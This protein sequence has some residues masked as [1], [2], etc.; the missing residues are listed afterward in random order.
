VSRRSRLFAIVAAI[1]FFVL[2]GSGVATALWS[3]TATISANVKVANL[4]DSCS[5]VTSMLNASFE[6]PVYAGAASVNFAND[7]TM[8]GWRAKDNAG[9]PVRIEVWTNNAFSVPAPV[10]NQFVELNADVAGTLWQ[11][12][13]TTPG[14]VLQ[15]SFLHR[16]R[17]GTDT[18][19]L[20]IG[21]P[22][23]LVAQG[24][25][26][27]D[28]TAWVRYSGAYVVP[29]GQ[30]TTELS[31]RAVSTGSGNDSIGN[32]L[33]DV[34]FGS[35]PCVTASTTVT[36]TTLAGST[37][38][39]GDVVE[40]TST[41]TNVGSSLSQ[42]SIFN[43][44]VPAGLT[45]L[46]GSITIDGVSRTDA[47]TDDAA[48]YVSGSQTVVA[49]I[50]SGATATAG[51][52]L[53]QGT[54]TVVVK[55]RAT[56]A[57]GTGGTTINTTPTVTYVN[58]L[59]TGWSRTATSNTVSISPVDGADLAVTVSVAPSPVQK[60]TGA[61]AISWSVV[62]TNNG[63]IASGANSTVTVTIPTNGGI[64]GTTVP[65]TTAGASC[66]AIS[67]GQSVCTI[68]AAM[69]SGASRT[70][71]I[72]RSIPA[73]AAVGASYS[74]SAT[75]QS[76][77]ADPVADNNT[78]SAAAS[79]V[80]TIAPTQP[81]T[82]TVSN[83]TTGTSLTLTWAAS[84]DAG[85]VVGYDVYRNGS[86]TPIASTT[87]ATTVNITGLTMWSSNT[88]TVVARDA[89]PNSSVASN[90]V[91]V[92]T[93]PG[94][95][96]TTNTFKLARTNVVETCIVASDND[97]GDALTGAWTNCGSNN[98]RNWTFVPSATDGYVKMRITTPN[99][100]IQ[101]G[102]GTTLTVNTASTAGSQD[103]LVTAVSGTSYTF[104][105]R[106]RPGYC[107]DRTGYT[108]ITL[109]VCNTSDAD[110][111]FVATQR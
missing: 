44:V 4:D 63:P 97:S 10:G 16:A 75:A 57:A 52:T 7:G 49:R 38:R 40:Y 72:A 101:A 39:V 76:T 64:T 106:S 90:S 30:T 66:A 55:Y 98:L 35:G 61:T 48:N 104:E 58:G 78:A 70:F 22:G 62:V 21:A 85:G 17:Q 51:G 24:T 29:A 111:V 42:G 79:V 102:T 69:A 18:M 50:G 84:T 73:A 36:N 47:T 34:S 31:F 108:A 71:T 89:V 13:T 56:I 67:G 94:N 41:V 43:A 81:G 19:E 99:L 37:Y 12:L 14:Q 105:S 100:Y 54:Q 45:Y 65:T 83:N 28:T 1:T 9:N 87:G 110:Q 96:N 93:S 60:S 8:P 23:A 77:V 3:T 6:Q 53:A 88:F 59:A 15:W 82:P 95:L 26:S 27:D 91:T 86:T 68:T 92:V 46:P 2:A 25:F 80:D 20:S 5:N 107:L 109:Q 33:D 11:R 103:W 74:L 32:F